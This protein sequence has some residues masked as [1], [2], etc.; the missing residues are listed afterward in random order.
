MFLALI[1]SDVELTQLQQAEESPIAIAR[2]SMMTGVAPDPMLVETSDL[3]LQRQ[4]ALL[5]HMEVREGLLEKKD[6]RV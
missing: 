5:S 1:V 4:L 6:M 3:E 2:Q